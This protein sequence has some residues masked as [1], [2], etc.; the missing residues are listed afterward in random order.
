MILTLALATFLAAHALIPLGFVSPRP[1]PVRGAP[2]WPFD[3]EHSWL[4]GLG[5]R[6]A[7]VRAAGAVLVAVQ[8]A[9]YVWAALALVGLLDPAT[10]VPGVVLGSAASLVLLEAAF[11]RWLVVGIAIDLVL[12]WATT[13]AGWRPD[14]LG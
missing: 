4:R 9:A 10:V 2:A 6:S 3:L 5:L 12:L 7:A 11:H 13:I 8:L 1:Q 14:T